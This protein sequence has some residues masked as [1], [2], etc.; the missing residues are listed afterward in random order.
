MSGQ[1]DGLRAE[2]RRFRSL[3]RQFPDE[4]KLDEQAEILAAELERRATALDGK[5]S[6]GHM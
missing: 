1:A 2:A 4:K 6:D 3:A 5:S